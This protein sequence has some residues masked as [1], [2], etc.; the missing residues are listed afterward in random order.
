MKQ[1]SEY[2]DCDISPVQMPLATMKELFGAWLFKELVQWLRNMIFIES[3]LDD[4]TH[5]KKNDTPGCPN[6]A[7]SRC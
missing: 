3:I 4:K 2:P 5:A 7:A 1:L 6:N